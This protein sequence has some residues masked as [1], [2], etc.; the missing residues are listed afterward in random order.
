MKIGTVAEKEIKIINYTGRYMSDRKI[1]TVN[2][3]Y[4]KDVKVHEIV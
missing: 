4:M 3:E 2:K 1:N